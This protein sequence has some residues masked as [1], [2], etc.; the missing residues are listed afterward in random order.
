MSKEGSTKHDKM[1]NKC[2]VQVYFESKHRPDVLDKRLDVLETVCSLDHDFLHK[3]TQEASRTAQLTTG[4]EAFH[5]SKILSE[6][7]HYFWN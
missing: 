2:L 1:I 6:T 4:S 5:F 3:Y 7:W